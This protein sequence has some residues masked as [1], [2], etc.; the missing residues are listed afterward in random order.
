MTGGTRKGSTARPLGRK[1][2]AALFLVFL[3]VSFG[4]CHSSSPPP[5]GKKDGGADAV[6]CGRDGGSRRANGTA[7]GCA[8]DCASGFCVDGLCCNSACT[9]TC[10]SCGTTSA[11]GTCSFVAAGDPPRSPALCPKSAASTCGLDGACDGKGDCRAYVKGSVCQAGSCSG[12]SVGGVRVCDGAGSCV[13]GAAT[14]CAPFNC[15]TSTG[16]CFTQCASDGDCSPGVKCVN[17]SCGKRLTGASCSAAS[18]CA[19]GFCV[20]GLC[21]NSACAGPCVSCNQ[22]DRLGSCWPIA[23]GVADPRAICVKSEPSTC[24]LTGVCDGSG[25][26]TKYAVETVCT[27]PSCSGDK[28]NTAGTCDGLGT[29]RPPGV[30]S[31]SPY[32][33]AGGACVSQCASD[34]DCVD[35]HTCVNGSCGPKALGRPCAAGGEC[36]SGFCA[37]GVC[38]AT[39]CTGSCRS[40]ALSSS[41]GTCSP[42]SRGGVDP[43][44]VC[45]DQHASSCGTDGTCDG[46]GACHSYGAGTECAPEACA[47]G[48]YTPASICDSNG[49]CRAPDE[50][51]CAP[52]V[53]N[54]ARCY[55]AC[56]SDASCSSGNVCVQGSCGPKPNGAFCSTGSECQS[57]QCAEGVCCATSC[58]GACFSCALAGSMGLCAPVPTGQ[59]DP[60]AVCVDQGAASCGTDGKCQAG[61]CQKY[62]S[63]TACTSASCPL[64]GGTFTAGGTCDG[65]GTCNT[66]AP[67]ACFPF[68]CGLNACESTCTKDGDCAPGQYCSAAGSCGLKPNGA[69][70]Q[71]GT[72]CQSGICAQGVCCA[73]ACTGTCLSCA[74]VGGL[75]ACSPV[76]SGGSDPAGIC[77]N[78]GAPSCG[79]TGFCNGAGGCQ[80]YSAGTQCAASS[81]PAGSTLDTLVR[82]CDGAGTCKPATTQSCFPYVCNAT[83]QAACVA[84]C[85]S[86]ADCAA[87]Q[88][89]NAGSCG[90]KR[91]GQICAAG[92]DCASG[93]CVD[94]VCCGA[95]SCGTCQAC[96]LAGSAGSCQPVAAG[97]AEPHQLCPPSPPCGFDGTCNGAGACRNTGAGTSCAPTTCAGSSSIVST[98]NGTGTC[99]PTSIA[100]PA[101]FVCGPAA[102]LTACTADADCVTGYTC[103][104]GICTNLK[105]LGSTCAGVADCL[106]GMCT[107]GV[108]CASAACGA[109]S[110]C[111]IAGKA[112]TCAPVPAGPDPTARCADMG[113]ASCGTTGLCDG[114]GHCPDYP[115]GTTCAASACKSGRTSILV[116]TSTCDGAGKCV[117]GATT[118]CTP[119]ACVSAAC[120][121]G[122]KVTTDCAPGY[123]CKA[124]SDGGASQLVCR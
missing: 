63:G 56:G 111:N 80:L 102:C 82:T 47:A 93:Y 104:G 51:S 90:L 13:A 74:L 76:P 92:S 9:E 83:T 69:V 24:G 5:A 18:Q 11:P 37:D 89:C 75:G 85:A 17:G 1:L 77:A 71:L 52:Y 38:C 33:C 73:T 97:S 66:P 42:V 53:C 79:T 39:A 25:G 31:C 124:G 107:D 48:I 46:T 70:C 105:P 41:L 72:D 67:S 30:E 4:S 84:V 27:V 115:A 62:Q 108:C 64:P 6:A 40:C 96:N 15:D 81:C 78:Q 113:S 68:I 88:F 35:G 32:A 23:A 45:V 118:D 109:C 8:G 119:Q 58:T 122:C 91:L 20:D 59:P 60:A 26:C 123:N 116:G 101:H 117:A 61:A 22:S 99:A 7:C 3:A 103:Q 110:A 94:G 10:K 50:L 54:G 34:A 112:G 86:D 49:N 21:C 114:A 121:V 87:G 2:G 29:C 65:A 16:A 14:I 28:L 55:T 95:G 12:A 44:G 106:S 36:A 100:C 43:H 98:C 19:S 57:G 120:T